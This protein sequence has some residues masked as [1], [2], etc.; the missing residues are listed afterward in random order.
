MLKFSKLLTQRHLKYTRKIQTNLFTPK[1]LI[2]YPLVFGSSV[3]I[4]G[5]A[6]QLAS[7]DD[8][9]QNYVFHKLVEFTSRITRAT[10]VL[11][12]VCY[13]LVSHLF[14]KFFSSVV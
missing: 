10:R 9:S 7:R 2:Y 6:Y 14:I 1:K 13:N 11:V 12:H 3:G 8:N 5:A 4:I